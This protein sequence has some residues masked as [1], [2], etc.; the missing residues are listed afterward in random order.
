VTLLG[1]TEVRLQKANLKKQTRAQ[2][3]HKHVYQSGVCPT[4]P[5]QEP[6]KKESCDNNTQVSERSNGEEACLIRF[7][8]SGEKR[9]GQ[10][11]YSIGGNSLTTT[12]TL[13]EEKKKE[14]NRRKVKLKKGKRWA[15]KQPP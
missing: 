5:G 14:Q 4:L 12:K 6:I 10:N 2:K 9:L 8:N 1:G 11:N 13:K 3:W 7:L 15:T